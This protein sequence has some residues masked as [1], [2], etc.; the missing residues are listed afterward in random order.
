MMALIGAF[1]GWE[2]MFLTLF[3]ATL[4][5]AL[6]GVVLMLK[7]GFTPKSK[8]PLGTFLGASGILVLFTGGAVLE[9]YKGL[10]RAP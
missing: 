9:W 1:F 10:F 7:G 8:L 6:I 4:G 2:K 5:A 3:Q